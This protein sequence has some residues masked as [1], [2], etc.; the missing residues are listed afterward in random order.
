MKRKR[1]TI[2]GGISENISYYTLTRNTNFKVQQAY[3]KL[4]L[5]YD[6]MISGIVQTI[7]LLRQRSLHNATLR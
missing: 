4:K 7:P 2:D 3:D 5:L 1:V 6:K